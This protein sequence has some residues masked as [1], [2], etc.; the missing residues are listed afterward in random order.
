[1]RYKYPSTRGRYGLVGT[2]CSTAV[3]L[4]LYC[5]DGG[6]VDV[7]V[8]RGGCL[9]GGGS[10]AI[11]EIP[12]GNKTTKPV[13]FTNPFTSDA[14]K[15]VTHF[16][17]HG[18]IVQCFPITAQ[19]TRTVNSTSNPSYRC[20]KKGGSGA[21]RTTNPRVWL[22]LFDEEPETCKREMKLQL[23][24]NGKQLMP[25]NV[26][27]FPPA[28]CCALIFCRSRSMVMRQCSTFHGRCALCHYRL[29]CP[30]SYVT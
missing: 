30:A 29:P 19:L 23:I 7:W 11:H 3:V 22:F 6:V 18:Q 4:L 24:G 20:S 26:L 15:V 12:G 27:D 13:H 17:E 9:M 14:P 28:T 1:M 8:V 10:F 16:G 2:C 21:T 25:I 5:C